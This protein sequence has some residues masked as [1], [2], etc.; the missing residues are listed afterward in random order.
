MNEEFIKK[1]LDSFEEKAKTVND[2]FKNA[3]WDFVNA[4]MY[5][6]SIGAKASSV[7]EEFIPNALD[8]ELITLEESKAIIG[9]VMK[10]SSNLCLEASVKAQNLLNEEQKIGLQ[11]KRP[12]LEEINSRILNLTKKYASYEDHAEGDWLLKKPVQENFTKSV[13]VDTLK[14]N[15]KLHSAAGITT[16]SYIKRQGVGCCDYCKSLVGEY[17]IGKAPDEIWSFH[18]GCTCSIEY[19]TPFRKEKITFETD[20]NGRTAKITEDIE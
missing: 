19:V 2:M 11:T 5:S 18:K 20:E 6:N 16:R 7:L 4:S 13:V 17:E 12:N 14:Q 8:N 10:R 1:V 9:T 15:C 3:K